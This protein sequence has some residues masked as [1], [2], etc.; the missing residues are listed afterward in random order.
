MEKKEAR[1]RD[2]MA[3]AAIMTRG[4]R[5]RVFQ[6]TAPR[7]TEKWGAESDERKLQHPRRRA[8]VRRTQTLSGDDPT[9]GPG[10]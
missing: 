10:A 8:R 3:K 5:R 2:N 4:W 9:T 1:E 7:D 6:A